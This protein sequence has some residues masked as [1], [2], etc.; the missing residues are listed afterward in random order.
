MTKPDDAILADTGQPDQADPSHDPAPIAAP[1][2]GDHSG[3][4]V[5]FDAEAAVD[6]LTAGMPDVQ[7]HAIDAAEQD[8][9][10]I[11]SG[12]RDAQGTAYDPKIH[13]TGKDGAGIKTAAGNWRKRRGAGNIKSM[14]GNNRQPE[15][16]APT[17]P[18]PEH[19]A[20]AMGTVDTLLGL[21]TAMLGGDFMPLNENG[22]DERQNMIEVYARY[23]HYK[24]VTDIPPGLAVVA[25]TAGYYAARLT[26]PTTRKRLAIGGLWVK[27]KWQNWRNRKK[28]RFDPD[29]ARSDHGNDPERQDNPS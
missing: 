23:Y 1:P 3:G 6:E 13:A 24:G 20:A 9:A 8:A 26:K 21:S 28:K 4:A 10:E 11:E 15:S 12:D 29:G 25:I 18:T 22:M 16:V 17:G 5:Q 27:S 19:Y 7:Q 2:E 14:I